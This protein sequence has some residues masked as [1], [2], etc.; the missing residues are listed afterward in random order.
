MSIQN[1]RPIWRV[2]SSDSVEFEKIEERLGAGR[3][4]FFAGR[5]ANP[6]AQILLGQPRQRLGVGLQRIGP[7]EVDQQGDVLHGDR[8]QAPRH[9]LPVALEEDEGH[10]RLKQHHRRDDDDQRPRIEAFRHAIADFAHDAPER[11]AHLVQGRGVGG[12]V[13]HSGYRM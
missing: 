3:G 8:R 11:A 1:G 7:V 4:Q 5:E 6:Q 12:R 10:H 9:R 2:N 13:H